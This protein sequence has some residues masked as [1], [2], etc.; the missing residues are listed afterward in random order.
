M[1]LAGII[2]RYREQLERTHGH[3]LLPGHRR[4][5]DAI[6]ECRT[7]ACGQV[8]FDCPR[9]HT[10]EARPCSCGHRICPV[11]RNFET[12]RW[13]ERQ[14]DKLL[15]V[16]YYMVTVTLPGVLRPLAWTHQRLVYD[17]MFRASHEAMLELAA[18]HRHFGAE[19]AM[20]GMLQT[21]VRNRNYHP[22]IHYI[23]PGG[24]IDR[25]RRVWKKKTGKWLFPERALS[26]LFRGKLRDR[27][28]AAG[29][30]VTNAIYD[31]DLVADVEY[32]GTGEPGLKYMSRYLYRGVLPEQSIVSDTEGKVTFCYTDSKGAEQTRTMP[33]A[34]FLWLL[35]HH[36]LPKGYQRVRSYGFLHHNAKKTL[37]LVQYTL[38]VA[39]DIRPEPKRPAWFCPRCHAAMVAVAFIHPRACKPVGRGPP[40]P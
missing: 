30:H 37:Q 28:L 4:A 5:L 23:V 6:V 18:G 34:E 19:I 27:L 24:G 10:T 1:N 39:L 16:R 7:E 9:C 36:V 15:P 14:L 40:P 2:L 33:G 8:V 13:L 29:L 20:T 11:C 25:I 32:V 35:L 17:Q 21:H 26:K 12:T 22:H 31:H 38:K 3:E